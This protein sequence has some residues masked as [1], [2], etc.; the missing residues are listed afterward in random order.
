MKVLAGIIM[1]ALAAPLA[2]ETTS[3]KGEHAAAPISLP[4]LKDMNDVV[5]SVAFFQ[6]QVEAHVRHDELDK[7]HGPALTAGDIAAKAEE[8]AKSLPADKQKELAAHAATI[9]SIGKQLDKYG[10]AGK[11]AESKVY[12]E[13]LL[14]ESEAI[15]NLTGITASE[16]YVPKTAEG[17]TFLPH[18]DHTPK[19][20]GSF[21]MAPGNFYHLE[22]T[23]P[24]AG[25]FRVYIYDDH[26]KPITVEKVSG[27]ATYKEK[28]YD[29]KP[30]DGNAYFVAELP[31]DAPPVAIS[32][33]LNLTDPTSGKTATEHFD[34]EFDKLTEDKPAEAPKAAKAARKSQ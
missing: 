28:A 11:A 29:L 8:F 12:A 7:L 18:M 13:K 16:D 22:G 17:G 3:D 27:K 9:K 15:Q 21:F 20:G 24:A 25:E 23:Y 31:K 26:T 5:N 33:D 1:V 2:A 4:Q 34:F 30:S 6:R 19:H 32:A 10:D 14:K